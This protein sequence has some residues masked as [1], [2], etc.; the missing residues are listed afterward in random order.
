MVLFKFESRPLFRITPCLHAGLS[1]RKH[2][3]QVCC[4]Q[5]VAHELDLSRANK[6]EPPK[7]H[8]H[9]KRI[10]TFQ[11]L[12]TLPGVDYTVFVFIHISFPL[13]A[14]LFF[15]IVLS[16]LCCSC[17]AWHGSLNLQLKPFN[18]L[19][20]FSGPYTSAFV[21][22]KSGANLGRGGGGWVL[23]G[24]QLNPQIKTANVEDL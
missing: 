1:N 24:V 11:A 8:V 12:Q 23:E 21:F 2:R 20:Y 18:L 4:V 19:C 14:Y 17:I 9:I 3:R 15:S 6:G 7:L 22:Y 13:V 16:H 5:I 10:T